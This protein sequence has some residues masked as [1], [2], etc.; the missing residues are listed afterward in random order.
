MTYRDCGDGSGMY[1]WLPTVQGA[2]VWA[3]SRVFWLSAS[4]RY[5]QSSP[6]TAS[7]SDL[8]Q[9]V[10]E[11]EWISGN[12]GLRTASSWSP[13]LT[14]FV[15]LPQ[16]IRFTLY[17]LYSRE[18]D[19]FITIYDAAIPSMGGILKTYANAPVF[20]T[21]CLDGIFSWSGCGGK[22]N[23]DLQPTWRYYKARGEYGSIL[24]WFRMRGGR[25]IE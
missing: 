12:P 10:N 24:G 21:F 18:H 14:M 22:L 17:S 9:K 1:Q 23:I 13:E 3:P 25:T 16:D 19:N 15:K 11:L 20:E 4:V 8:I 5:N 7:S 2:L 6:G